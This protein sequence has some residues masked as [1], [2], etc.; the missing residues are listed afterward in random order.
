[1]GADEV[2]LLP[3]PSDI[4]L[5]GKVRV[6]DVVVETR[7]PVTSGDGSSNGGGDQENV[8]GS[9]VKSEAEQLHQVGERLKQVVSHLDTS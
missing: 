1:L 7:I 2:A 5:Q 3:S 9:C 6:P 8:G 4:A